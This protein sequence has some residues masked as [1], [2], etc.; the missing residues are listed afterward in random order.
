[1]FDFTG[2]FTPS[3]RATAR[4]ER[5]VTYTVFK[6]DQPFAMLNAVPLLAARTL[7]GFVKATPECSWR[8][9]CC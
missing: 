4:D 3:K 1:M 7:A 5:P 9:E 8:L 6:D 2:P